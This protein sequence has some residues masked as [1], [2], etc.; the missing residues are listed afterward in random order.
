MRRRERRSKVQF[1]ARRCRRRRHF[2]CL[3]ALVATSV[4]PLMRACRRCKNCRSVSVSS[5]GFH[6]RRCRRWRYVKKSI[7]PVFS[8]STALSVTSPV[9]SAFTSKGDQRA[10]ADGRVPPVRI[11]A[12]ECERLSPISPLP[13]PLMAL[14]NVPPVFSPA[15][16]YR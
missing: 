1:R 4:P 13:L 15:W 3:N 5:P 2:P 12:G 16:R 11:G 6:H 8:S 9:L 7:P 10:A 14:S